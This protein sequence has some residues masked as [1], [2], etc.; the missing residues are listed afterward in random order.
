MV[1]LW[2][3]SIFS[4]GI[5]IW[6][7]LPQLI[8]VVSDTFRNNSNRIQGLSKVV[9]SLRE[10][11]ETLQTGLLPEVQKWENLKFLDPPWGRLTYES[12]HQLRSQGSELLPTLKRLREV[13]Q[14]LKTLSLE[15]RSRQAQA[16]MQASVCFALVPAFSLILY[17][18]LPG[19]SDE[20][21]IWLSLSAGALLMAGLGACWLFSLASSASWGGLPA[22]AR[23]WVVSIFCFG[24]KF[25]A[26]LRAGEPADLAWTKNYQA[27]SVESTHLADFWGTS[28]WKDPEFSK[29]HP[30][31]SSLRGAITSIRKSVQVS[32]MEG[33]PC[34]DRI[35]AALLAL[36][37]EWKAQV[38]REIGILATRSLKPLFVLIGPSLLGLLFLG[39]GLSWKNFMGMD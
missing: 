8:R 27:L 22:Y 34:G 1:L 37:L 4:F 17:M 10:L 5:G 20:T 19:L 14:E 26:M 15:V 13:A 2:I 32:L 6:R 3:V 23:P 35:E 33:S 18:L 31:F 25:L 7:L 9:Q 29:P 12:I 21:I 11:E 24:E 28:I 30:A 39:L 16:L 38:E 36:R